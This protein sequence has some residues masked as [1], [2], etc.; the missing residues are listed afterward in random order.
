MKTYSDI[1]C[2]VKNEIDQMKRRDGDLPKTAYVVMEIVI[3]LKTLAPWEGFD[4][5]KPLAQNIRPIV[6]EVMHG[7]KNVNRGKEDLDLDVI[8]LSPDAYERLDD[9]IGDKKRVGKSIDDLP[10]MA[11]KQKLKKRLRKVS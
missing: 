3:R 11:K 6:E 4:N 1:R 5:H 10:Y 7:T 2:L 9:V 8:Y